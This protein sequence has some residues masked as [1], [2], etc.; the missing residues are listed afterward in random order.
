MGGLCMAL[1]LALQCYSKKGMSEGA[2]EPTKLRQWDAV[3]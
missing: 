2:Y 1:A 3:C